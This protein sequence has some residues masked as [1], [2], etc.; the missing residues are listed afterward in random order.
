MHELIDR[1]AAGPIRRIAFA[2]ALIVVLV[3]AT[4]FVVV[5][6]FDGST[7]KY[8]RALKA[9][10]LAFTT[11]NARSGQ[12]DILNA[13][14][15]Y[16]ANPDA[17]NRLA[18]TGFSGTLTDQLQEID[19]DSYTAAQRAAARAVIAAAVP[20][21]DA[22]RSLGNASD[23]A[24]RAAASS[25]LHTALGELDVRFDAVAAADRQPAEATLHATERNAKS[26][27]IICIV[28]GGLA[29]LLV[30]ALTL[31]VVRLV[32]NLFGQIQVT[33]GE[34]D[35]TTR[36]LRAASEAATTATTQQLAAIS[37]VAATLEEMSASSAA[38]AENAHT[39]AASALETGERSQQIGQML[40]LV[41]GIA[42]Q[43]NLLALNAA[44]EAA[45]AGDA[46]RGFAVVAS[47]IRKLADRTMRF[48]EAI[49]QLAVGIQEKSNS[50]ILATENSMA[51][52]D[53]QKEASEQAAT[54]MVKIQ[55]AAEQLA[56]QQQQRADTAAHVEEL[57]QALER[58]LAHYGEEGSTNGASSADGRGS[59][60]PALS[61][62]R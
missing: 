5:F 28:I 38:I 40:G 50:T 1:G 16:A 43:T 46:G 3:A 33:S 51:A 31:Y 62:G 7:S 30:F 44:I 48:T 8:D 2:S 12:Y 32:Q 54:A 58:I 18:L 45:R 52:T 57:V 39:T 26:T 24:A 11:S 60:K 15:L 47:E 36:E 25:R 10:S 49:R 17:A 34:L 61:A 56:E 13:D 23:A 59:S 53:D 9:E 6:R 29:I 35:G 19:R 4:I 14:R 21:T 20:V 22:I 55:S 37:E 27:R 41:N 42:E